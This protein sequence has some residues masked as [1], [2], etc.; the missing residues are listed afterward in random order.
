MLFNSL[1]FALFLAI[2]LFVYALASS[3]G[4]RRVV[5]LVASYAFYAAWS[6]PFV[7]LLALSTIVDFHLARRMAVEERPKR[8][9]MLLLVSLLTN[10]GLLGYFKYGGF[11]LE[12]FQTLAAQFGVTFLPAAWEVVL[13]VG[14]SFYTFQTLSYSIDVYRNAAT[15]ERDPVR[16]ALYV[17]FFPQLVAGPIV[18]ATA[19]LPQTE[20]M[21]LP[22]WRVFAWGATLL[23]AGLWLK[24][25]VA[26]ALLAPV[27]DVVYA[28]PEA[29][30]SLDIFTALIGFSGQIYADFAGYSLCAIGVALMFGFHLPDNFRFPYAAVGFSEFWR[31]WHISLSTWLRDYLYRPLGGRDPDFARTARNLMI[32]MLLGGLWH[33]A[34]WLF[35]LWGALHGALL[36]I[37]HA[38]RRHQRACGRPQHVFSRRPWAGMLVTFLIVTL[39]WI[40]FRS[41]SLEVAG[42]IVFGLVAFER[43]IGLGLDQLLIVWLSLVAMIWGSW[44]MRHR[45]LAEV[46][47]RLT[48][49]TRGLL[50]TAVVLLLFMVSGGDERAFLYFQF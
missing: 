1:T 9:R 23:L 20:A 45:T 12:S 19:F 27:V 4:R 7:L 5:L 22:V 43:Q 26:D 15:V 13:P 14:I 37:E 42:A 24:V 16:F 3:A 35:V 29:Y 17:S 30:S 2:T 6:P 34:S 44:L 46:Y 36:V 47:G 25:F 40:P 50:I 11:L 21:G 31:R 8:R 39:V 18:R 10:L 38:W 33:G 48:P 49:A 41:P 32:T 28:R